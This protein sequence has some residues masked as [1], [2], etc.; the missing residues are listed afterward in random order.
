M[1][2]AL[3]AL[4][5][6]TLP[7]AG[8][9]RRKG[10]TEHLQTWVRGPTRGSQHVRAHR[11]TGLGPT[12]PWGR[13]PLHQVPPDHQV[14]FHQLRSHQ[15]TG[16]RMTRSCPKAP[17]RVPR[18]QLPPSHNPHPTAMQQPL[19][20]GAQPLQHPPAPPRPHVPLCPPCAAPA[21]LP[22]KPAGSTGPA[23]PGFGLG[24]GEQR[25]HWRGAGRRKRVGTSLLGPNLGTPKLGGGPGRD[26]P[27]PIAGHRVSPV[28]R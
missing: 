21:A 15:A 11:T 12:K 19:G 28:P 26:T 1:A 22:R 25:W 17:R 20:A 27:V 14:G 7:R 6:G 4:L 18:A 3:P 23:P 24:A 5:S 16:S 8:Q 9:E 10:G 2:V 13:E